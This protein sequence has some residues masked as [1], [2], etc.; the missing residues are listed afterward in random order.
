M[1]SDAD[2]DADIDADVDADIDSD[3]DAGRYGCRCGQHGG[4]RSV[5]DCD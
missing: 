3:I 2:I 4:Y 5:R 1:R